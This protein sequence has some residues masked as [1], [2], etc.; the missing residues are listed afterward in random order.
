MPNAGCIC[1]ITLQRRPA[2]RQEAA[3]LNPDLTCVVMWGRP[4]SL[5]ASADLQG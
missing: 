4:S 2:V 3:N 5:L 1:V